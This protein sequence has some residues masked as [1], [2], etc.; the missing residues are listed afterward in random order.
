MV[1]NTS[2][3]QVALKK[4][5]LESVVEPFPLSVKQIK[6]SPS[7]FVFNIAARN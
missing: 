5:L 6:Q 1:A 4:S 7:I 2:V 3:Q